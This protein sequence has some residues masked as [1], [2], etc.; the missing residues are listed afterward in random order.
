MANQ[1][2]DTPTRIP[3]D[4]DDASPMQLSTVKMRKTRP[5]SADLIKQRA[6]TNLAAI[7]SLLE[8]QVSLE[9]DHEILTIL[10]NQQAN[11]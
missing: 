1:I 2:A 5:K 4:K 11:L 10:E 3:P 6:D 7:M 8:I 9:S